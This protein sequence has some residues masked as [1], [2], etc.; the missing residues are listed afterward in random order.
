MRL[1]DIQCDPRPIAVARIGLGLATIFNAGEMFALLTQIAGG[2]LGL[3]VHPLIPHPSEPAVL[4]YLV[5]SVLAGLAITVGWRTAG[6]A[7]VSTLL[8]VFVF[9]WDH[10]T[11]SSHRF[12]ATLLV[13]YL[14]FA[15][16]DTAWS[17]SRREGSVPWWP[18]L[19]M[20]TQLSICYFFAAISKLNLPFISGKPLSQWVWAPLPGWM[21]GL[22]AIGTI[23][24]ELVLAFGFWF[25]ATRRLAVVFGLMLHGSILVLMKDQTLPLIAFA[26]SCVSLY[27][28]FLFRPAIRAGQKQETRANAP[29]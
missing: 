4:A 26:L 8:S 3:P 16:S 6:A 21:F 9:L 11:Y 24:I 5:L 12:L 22:M 29:T 19:L 23:A 14:V 15:R 18:Q 20:M 25:R 28:L 27:G 2:K 17:V 1:T 10:Q 7:A 13:A